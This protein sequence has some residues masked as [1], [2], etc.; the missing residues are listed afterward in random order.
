MGR[1]TVIIPHA[2]VLIIFVLSPRLAVPFGEFIPSV[3]AAAYLCILILM[4][5]ITINIQILIYICFICSFIYFRTIF[6]EDATDTALLKLSVGMLLAYFLGVAY[7]TRFNLSEVLRIITIS[8]VLNSVLIIVEFI[9][10]E[11]KATIENMLIQNNSGLIY[12]DHPFQMRGV[13][14][15]GGA[16][17]SIFNF[18]CV[19]LLLYEVNFKKNIF[20]IFSVCVLLVSCVVIG[21]TGLATILMLLFFWIFTNLMKKNYRYSKFALISAVLVLISYLFYFL[22]TEVLHKDYLIWS[23]E[24]FTLFNGSENPTL[25]HLAPMIVFP[26]GW[27]LLFGSGSFERQLGYVQSD[28]GYLKTLH[29]GGFLF[30]FLF[31]GFFLV[32]TIFLSNMKKRHLAFLLLIFFIFELKEPFFVQNINSRFWF[33][34][35]GFISPVFHRSNRAAD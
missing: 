5:T 24:I 30:C 23:T 12:A 14:S 29:F 3:I 17:L 32:L 11:L 33:F 9:I 16:A 27:H 1:D 8:G 34:V 7:S 6:T 25:A 21:R 2:I 26:E 31:Y 13:A 20:S 15:A 10:P 4:K 28:I 22:E 18:T 19:Y 35:A